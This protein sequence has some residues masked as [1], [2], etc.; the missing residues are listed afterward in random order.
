MIKTFLI[1]S[2]S[3]ILGALFAC[4]Q[5]HPP[6]TPA[7]IEDTEGDVGRAEAALE[8]ARKL[9]A[10]TYAPNL[11]VAAVEALEKGDPSELLARAAMDEAIR[12]REEAKLAADHQIR[13][14][15]TLFTVVEAV[16][17][18]DPPNRYS[19]P[20]DSQLVNF[21]DELSRAQNAYQAGDFALAGLIAQEV[22]LQ[23]AGSPT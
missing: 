19:L 15:R 20:S 22:S 17:S 7:T 9:E 4:E 23:L 12:V 21:R 2:C 13:A 1:A 11:Y 10:D 8:Q 18:H 5:R 6:E 16:L 3:S 14:A